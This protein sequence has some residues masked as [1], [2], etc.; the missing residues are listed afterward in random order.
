MPAKP[1]APATERNRAPIL[2]ILKCEFDERRRVLEIGSGSGQHAVY[3]A[4][5]LPHLFWQT[6]DLPRNHEGILAWVESANLENLAPPL[7]LDVADCDTSVHRVDIKFDAVFSA[8]TAHIM[9]YSMVESMFRLVASLLPADGLFCLYGPF[10]QDGSFSSESN[11]AF[12][13]SLRAQDP[14][15]GIRDL[16]DLDILAAGGDMSPHAIYAMPANNLMVLWRKG[17]LR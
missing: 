8:N 17:K 7:L 3:F 15:M 13:D 10:K 11:A 6:S 4:E 1:S 16:E 2:A 9:S 5:A 14:Q 12:D